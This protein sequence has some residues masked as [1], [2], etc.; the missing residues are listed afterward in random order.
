[1]Q[2]IYYFTDNRI[3]IGQWINNSMHGYGEFSWKDGKKYAGYYTHDKKEGFGIY[4][5]ENPH[6]VYIGFWK[7]GKQEGVGKY[8]N[9]NEVRYGVWTQGKRTKQFRNE[10]EALEAL[11]P[12]QRVFK[13]LFSYDINDITAFLL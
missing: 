9:A 8:I 1:M 5:W 3:Y 12:N 11:E 4:Y 10:S 13:N 2:G 6:R 7:G